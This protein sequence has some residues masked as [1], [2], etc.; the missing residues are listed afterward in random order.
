MID[1][2]I[3]SDASNVLFSIHPKDGSR[4]TMEARI[5]TD[6]L[7]DIVLDQ[8]TWLSAA[9]QSEFFTMISGHPW[10]R[11]PLGNLYEK[12][13]HVRL[14]ADLTT[15]S[16]MCI[17]TTNK[18]I[19]LPVV[20]CVVSLSSSSNLQDANH[21]QLPFYCWPVSPTF[22]SFNAIICTVEMIFL[23][24]STV[25][26]SHDI[27]EQGLDFIRR[28]IPTHF[29]KN[30]QCCIVFVTPDEERG[31]Q[32][33]SNRYPILESFPELELCYCVLPIGTS[34]FTSSQVHKLWARKLDARI[35][36]YSTLPLLI[37]FFIFQ[38]GSRNGWVKR[39][40]MCNSIKLPFSFF[41][42]LF[43]YV[44]Y[45]TIMTNHHCHIRKKNYL[46]KKFILHKSKEKI[47]AISDSIPSPIFIQFQ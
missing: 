46:K 22:T 29:W 42:Y 5:V 40:L 8:L 26:G 27:K 39:D 34:E 17:S 2:P 23:L 47:S 32:L 9:E 12:F 10:L 3:P 20:P 36:L 28:N 19:P 24:Q 1:D 30:R 45:C 35:L 44:K 21:N 13:A 41:L 43:L 25:S 16:L 33:I 11:S 7:F 18:L 4:E 37:L 31:I 38:V 14:T 15:K 6:H